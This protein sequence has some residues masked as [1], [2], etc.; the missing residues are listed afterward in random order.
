MEKYD[1]ITF[2]INIFWRETQC[3]VIAKKCGRITQEE[4]GKS[5]QICDYC[6][7]I[8]QYIPEQFLIGKRG[9]ALNKDLEQ[10]FIDQYIKSSPE[11]DQYLFDHK[12]EDLSKRRMENMAKLE[13]GKQILEE[14]ARTPK[15]PSCGSSNI[16]NIGLVNRAVSTKLF[17]LA[18]SKIGKT[19]KCNNCGSMW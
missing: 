9:I 17:G 1:K 19:H 4:Y 7:S 13:H 8:M 2:I 10:Q 6:N 15:C 11:F 5:K 3:F 16:S 18:S 14:Q 12:D